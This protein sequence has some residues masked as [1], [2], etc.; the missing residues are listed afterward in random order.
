M[1]EDL[2]LKNTPIK[3]LPKDLQVGG[4]LFLENSQIYALP[5]NMGIDGGLDLE[6]TP[7]AQLPSNL[8][9]GDYLNIQGTNIT[10]LPKDLYVGQNLLMDTDKIA[11]D[12]A[13]QSIMARGVIWP[14]PERYG[15]ARAESGDG[16]VY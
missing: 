10:S 5:D 16:I 12:A 6:N 7:I 13:F 1:I 2:D 8:F 4:N 14:R 3:T 15:D 9:V 11:R